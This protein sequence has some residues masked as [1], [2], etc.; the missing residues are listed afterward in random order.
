MATKRGRAGPPR[1]LGTSNFLVDLGLGD[2]RAEAA[3]FGEV[4][5]PTLHAATD[6]QHAD[7][8]DGNRL[9][10][11]RG[12]TGALDLYAWW[13]KA[14][15][16]KPPAGRTATVM[17]LADDRET[18]VMTWRFHNA[19]PVTITYSPLHAMNASI[20]METIELEFDRVE[21]G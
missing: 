3:G 5:L 11:R 15:G 10:L 4:I 13:D 16:S 2:P 1:L 9:I 6:A 7:D 21:M 18:I 19:R 14:R 12:S 17:L 20:L 8:F